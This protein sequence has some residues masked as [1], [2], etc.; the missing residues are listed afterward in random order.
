MSQRPPRSSLALGNQA[1]REKQFEKAVA[2]YDEAI[3]KQP[4]LA[5]SIA[6]NLALVRKQYRKRR[7]LNVKPSVAVCGWN[8]SSEVAQRVHMIAGLYESSASIEIISSLSPTA[9]RTVR[10]SISHLSYPLHTF[11]VQKECAFLQQTSRFVAAHPYDIVHLSQP[12]APNLIIAA[13]YKAFWHPTLF[14]DIDGDARLAASQQRR[15]PLELGQYLAQFNTLPGLNDSTGDLWTRLELGAMTAFDGVTIAKRHLQQQFSE[16][17]LVEAP[18]KSV[19][20]GL[21][22]THLNAAES[23]SAILL[24]WAEHLLFNHK[25]QDGTAWPNNSSSPGAQKQL[26]KLKALDDGKSNFDYSISAC[27]AIIKEKKI[28]NHEWFK[29]HHADFKRLG[30]IVHHF[31]VYGYKEDRTLTPFFDNQFYRSQYQIED[32]VNAL[33]YYLVEGW[34]LGH[35]PSE[36]FDFINYAKRYRVDRTDPLSHYINIGFGLNYQLEKKRDLIFKKQ[37]PNGTDIIDKLCNEVRFVN[38]F[39]LV[40]LEP[41]DQAYDPSCLNIHFVIPPFGIGGGGHMTIFRM[42]RYLEKFGHQVTIWIFNKP[43]VKIDLEEQYKKILLN[44]QTIKAEMRIISSGSFK[45]AGDVIIATG[46]D[47]VFPVMSAKFFK[48]RFYFVQDYEKEFFATGSKSVL[49]ELT[50][51]YDIDC[52]CA[53]PWLKALMINR[54]QKWAHDFYLAYDHHIFFPPQDKR[55]NKYVRLAVYGRN[56]TE[57]RGVE[58]IFAALEK[59]QQAGVEFLVDVF[60]AS[61]EFK[62][63]PFRCINHGVCSQEYLGHL[64]RRCDIGIVFSLTNY[65]LTPQ[66]MMACQLP[67]IE[68][69]TE[70]T[71][72]IF[73]EDSVLF[74]GPHPE[75]I[76]EKIHFLIEHRMER[77][78]LG[79]RGY[80]WVKQ[81]SWADSA[82]RVE[83]AL[84]DRLKAHQFIE[85]EKAT[86]EFSNIMKAT[87]VIPTHN[88]GLI[89]LKVIDSVFKQDT[90]WKFDV[91][92]IDS[93]STDG[94]VDAFFESNTRANISLVRIMKSEFGHGRTR[95]YAASISEG[96][97]IVFLTHDAI[98]ANRD[99]LYNLVSTLE[100][101]PNA[102]GAFGRHIAHDDAV[103]YTQLDMKNH[104][105]G[106]DQL[107]LSVSKKID[108]EAYE[109][110][111]SWR[112]RL[113]FFSDNNSCL[114]RSAW[115]NVPYRDVKY[116]EDQ[117][118]AQDIIDA[119]YEKV[120]A[121]TAVVKHSHDY[122]PEE[123]YNRAV[124]DGDFFKFFWGYQLVEKKNMKKI[125]ADMQQHDELLGFSNGLRKV[126]ISKRLSNIEMR[127]RGYVDGHQKLVSLFDAESIEKS[128]Y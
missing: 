121:P 125:I 100:H 45:E 41:A 40:D 102:A 31:C 33:A 114:R 89:F 16:A 77:L 101:F 65:S 30:D 75:D 9:D 64:Y 83:W 81:F 107:P 42:V 94:I 124:I 68:F 97:F 2:H 85:Q 27:E 87:V 22:E 15:E 115:E 86:I 34:Q 60:G 39:S 10:P 95:N 110:S 126:E 38:H 36:K 127:L 24:Q 6:A 5:R 4:Y 66:E 54:Y 117:L 7:K 18:S 120:Y 99:W 49:A 91:L 98:P 19:L 29:K 63:A 111:Q 122:T 57:R 92:V 109:K 44:Y 52:I 62:S 59:L 37:L 71:K 70:S 88:P 104:F 80:Q 23:S 25:P 84:L 17:F 58:L 78:A 106:F 128:R 26:P 116:G 103:Y 47:T 108:P 50:Y 73:P 82:K 74:A 11:S 123:T 90:P 32:D 48:R 76:T 35:E 1:L 69:K 3:T 72:A 53:S 67:V 79:N 105:D 96:E 51:Q 119:G 61:Q 21:L 46:W 118:W 112:Q 8:L 14:M 93:E 113:H 20:I 55:D 56:F 43:Q 28:L 12:T 13:F